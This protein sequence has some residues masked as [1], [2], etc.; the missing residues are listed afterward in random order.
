MS[1]RLRISSVVLLSLLCV[2]CGES[3]E[4]AIQRQ[5]EEELSN[6][7]KEGWLDWEPGPPAFDSMPPIKH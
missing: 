1:T 7:L 3:R 4:E 5:K 6:R 2:S